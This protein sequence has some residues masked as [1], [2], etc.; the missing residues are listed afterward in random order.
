MA[1][2]AADLVSVG[3]KAP[4]GQSGGLERRNQCTA[5]S[6]GGYGRVT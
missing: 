6:G 5:I 1:M 3:R 2:V 4:T